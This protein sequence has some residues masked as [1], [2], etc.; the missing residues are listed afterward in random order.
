MAT[1]K[2][3]DDLKQGVTNNILALYEEDRANAK[4][5]PDVDNW[6]GKLY[7]IILGDVAAPLH[8]VS[9]AFLLM[10]DSIVISEVRKPND[11][12]DRVLVRAYSKLV[13]PLDPPRPWPTGFPWP[14]LPAVTP[15]NR[16]ETRVRA[17]DVTLIVHDQLKEF[18]A[19]LDARQDEID[20]VEGAIEKLIGGVRTVFN[21]TNT[22]AQA[23]TVWPPLRD[24]LPQSTRD[25]LA[26]PNPP[27]PKRTRPVDTV[28]D[29]RARLGNVAG[30]MTSLVVTKKLQG[31]L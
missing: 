4:R 3:S 8:D 25:E 9:P 14:G 29:A 15:R 20:R 23:L 22:L 5:F 30:D 18:L 31:E 27:R 11:E 2:I 28:A 16:W 26:A 21:N 6:G 12:G 10:E 19:L 17:D 1:V 24:L 7:D 13:L